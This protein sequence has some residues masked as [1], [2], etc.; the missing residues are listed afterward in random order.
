[1][2][3]EIILDMVSVRVLTSNTCAIRVCKIPFVIKCFTPISSTKYVKTCFSLIITN[4]FSRMYSIK[5]TNTQH[6]VTAF[7]VDGIVKMKKIDYLKNGT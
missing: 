7:K 6:D 5:Y 4:I 1:M 3:I 2:V